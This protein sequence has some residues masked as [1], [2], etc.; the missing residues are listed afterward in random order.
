MKNN[1]TNTYSLLTTTF[2]TL[3]VVVSSCGST[4]NSAAEIGSS[5]IS[6]DELELTV[7][8]LSDAGQTPVVDGEVAGDTARSVLTALVQGA[9][10]KVI[11]KRYGQEI[12]KADR[13]KVDATI[14]QNTDTTSFSDHLKELI[15]ELNAGGLALKRIVAPDAETAAKMYDEAPASLGVMCV[16]HLVVKEEAKAKEALKKITDGADFATIAGEYSIEPN[17]KVSGGAL[18]GEKNAC[19]LLSEYQSSF[20]PDFTAGAL[21]AKPGVATG[22]V[23]SSFGYHI[24]LVRPFV[25]VAADISALLEANA[26]ELLFNGYITTSKIKVDSAYGRWNSA[27]GAIVAN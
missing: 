25:E 26:G 2:V 14:K 4:T 22:P 9:A 21:L 23:K 15:V 11:L 8:E 10:A 5:K 1:K 7:K 18:S 3:A 27:R 20:D 17:A 19:M 13:D 6:R 16:R 24:I 12:T